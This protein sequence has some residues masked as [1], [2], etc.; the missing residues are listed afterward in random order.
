VLV[1]PVTLNRLAANFLPTELLP[2]GQIV[3]DLTFFLCVA[4]DL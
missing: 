1:R 4:L 2:K 3:F